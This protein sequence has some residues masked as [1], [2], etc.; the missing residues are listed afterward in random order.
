VVERATYG[1]ADVRRLTRW[2][3]DQYAA[4]GFPETSA[5]EKANG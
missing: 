1:K 5:E 4:A 3:R 2:A